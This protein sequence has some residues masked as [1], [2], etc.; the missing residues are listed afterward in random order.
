MKGRDHSEYYI[1]MA[2]GEIGWKFV[3]CVKVL[4]YRVFLNIL[5]NILSS[6]IGWELPDQL[7]DCHL[8]Q[9]DSAP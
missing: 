2:P 1:K 8:V 9:T 7:S 4:Q 3:N 6:I 5:T